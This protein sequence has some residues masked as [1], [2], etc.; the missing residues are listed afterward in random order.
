MGLSGSAGT[1]LLVH[2]LELRLGNEA[3]ERLLHPNRVCLVPGATAPE[4]RSGVGLVSQDDVDAVLG[5]WPAGGVGDALA[6]EGSGDLQDAFPHLRQVEDA[7]DH[8]SGVR[9]RLQGRAFLG[10]VLDHQLAVAVGNSARDPEAPGGG[11]AHSPPNFFRKIFRVEL[12]HGLYDGLHQLAGGGVVGVLGDGYHADA[13]APQHGLE[14]HG[15]LPLA[16]ES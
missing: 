13:L 6:V 12:V 8:G 14:G 2:L 3:G 10:P 7:L 9:V 1:H 11:L 5:P 4:E 16:G 15:V